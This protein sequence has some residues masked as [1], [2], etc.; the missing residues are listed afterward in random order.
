MTARQGSYSVN[1]VG[2]ALLPAVEWRSEAYEDEFEGLILSPCAGHDRMWGAR[3]ADK[4][5]RK[6]SGR[7]GSWVRKQGAVG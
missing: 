5:A 3:P 6:G 7:P 2:L 1:H 4:T